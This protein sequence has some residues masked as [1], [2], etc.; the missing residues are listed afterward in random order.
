VH[1]DSRLPSSSDLPED[2]HGKRMRILMF[3]LYSSWIYTGFFRIYIF[4]GAANQLFFLPFLIAILISLYILFF[5]Y[6]SVRFYPVFLAVNLIG[7][8]FQIVH[9]YLGDISVTTIFYG[10]AIYLVPLNILFCSN[11]LS[12][13]NFL[14]QFKR[15]LIR[16][17][18][19]NLILS[20]LQTLTPNSSYSRGLSEG[21][22][23]T[24]SN[25]YSR[26]FGTFTSPA[27]FSIYLSLL[28]VVAIVTF[29]SKSKS[30]RLFLGFE[31]VTLYLVSGSRMVFF[32]LL[33]ILIFTFLSSQ[34]RV[35]FGFRTFV[36]LP[37]L[38]LILLQIFVSLKIG[39]VVALV[40][41]FS[42][43]NSSENTVAR[44]FNNFF[45]FLNHL[46]APFFGNGMGSHS[47]GTLGYSNRTNWIEIDAIKNMYE[48]GPFL[49][50]CWLGFR[51]ILFI[52]LLNMKNQSTSKAH[53]VLFSSIAVTLLSGQIS[54]QGTVTFGCWL[55]VLVVFVT[56]ELL[57][58]ANS[59]QYQ[60]R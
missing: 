54:S 20:L 58:P 59:H 21:G 41:R 49:G 45:G 2:K 55:M 50:I 28:T 35:R 29:S 9:F 27:G 42:D 48:L 19:P 6:K 4:P 34:K 47:I 8:G 14:S 43:A 44:I 26:A 52:Y 13:T 10:Y 22:Q 53:L 40:N 7:F 38:F 36:I 15:T 32:N 39:T 1:I 25:G 56:R 31:I 60:F 33:V 12:R 3:L 30:L 11:L 18:T 17:A 24:S 57:Q 46:D 16:S 5:L 51:Y 37:L 23:L